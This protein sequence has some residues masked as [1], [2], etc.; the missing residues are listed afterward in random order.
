MNY[1]RNIFG[2]ILFIIPISL[3][4]AP[5]RIVGGRDVLEGEFPSYVALLDQ[6]MDFNCGATAIAPDKLLTAAHCEVDSSW[7]AVLGVV[8]GETALADTSRHVGVLSVQNHPDYDPN[9][10]DNDITV[11]T[12]E[13]PDLSQFVSLY[14]G[15]NSLA[16]RMATATGFGVT[17]E[18]GDFPDITQTVDVPVITNQACNSTMRNVGSVEVYGDIYDLTAETRPTELMLCAGYADGGKD[19][20]QGDSGGPLY[21][22]DRAG[23]VQIGVTSWGF[24]CARPGLPGLYA[25]VSKF[26]DFIT[27]HAPSANFTSEVGLGSY[28]QRFSMIP[29]SACKAAVPADSI[30]LQS[31]ETGLTNTN[32]T[33]LGI[34]CPISGLVNS[35]NLKSRQMTVSAL[36]KNTSGASDTVSCTMQEYYGSS[37]QRSE[38]KS[39]EIDGGDETQVI[40]WNMD[41]A[42]QPEKPASVFSLT[43]DLPSQFQIVHL[44]LTSGLGETGAEPA[45]S[46]VSGGSSTPSLTNSFTF[47]GHTYQAIASSATFSGASSDA[48]GRTYLGETGYLAEIDS[49]DENDAILE[50]LLEL[51]GDDLSD[52]PYAT[53]GGNAAYLWI[54]GSDQNAE[55]TWVWKTS[56]NQFWNGD[57]DGTSVAGRFTNWGKNPNG[58]QMEPD[59]YL[60][61]QDG[62]GLAIESWPYNV[63]NYYGSAGEWNDIDLDNELYYLIEFDV[64]P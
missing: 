61:N 56:G 24:G 1:C 31:K 47:G 17:T 32:N 22:K 19:S 12:L 46:G 30:R 7:T 11:V 15:P 33:S 35:A 13:S 9:T 5:E 44:E 60:S 41:P 49:Q 50:E 28:D 59:D 27:E 10:M 62:L 57:S 14:Q 25:R 55:G 39:V 21:L 64:V 51:I 52:V 3:A 40:N 4:S 23:I 18:D 8:D 36:L 58:N 63:D 20:C 53:D 42:W 2:F 43:C 34:V 48:S 45:G 16:G 6:N 26:T 38:A 29:G 54:G 37:K